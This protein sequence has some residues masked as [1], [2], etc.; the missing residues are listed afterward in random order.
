M[1]NPDDRAH[2]ATTCPNLPPPTNNK[3]T[4]M[5]PI[6]FKMSG[7]LQEETA[8]VQDVLQHVLRLRE[9]DWTCLS[10]LLYVPH[11]DDSVCRSRH[12]CSAKEPAAQH[13]GD[14]GLH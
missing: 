7:R 12:Q 9:E 14:V 5:V 8:L 13:R 4:H 3:R 11:F 10:L 6:C 1:L 2:S